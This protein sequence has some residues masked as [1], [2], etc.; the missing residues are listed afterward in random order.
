MTIAIVH[1]GGDLRRGE[2]TRWLA[3][4][5]PRALVIL[6]SEGPGVGALARDLIAH[7][8]GSRP[9]WR[10][11]RGFDT[12]TQLAV[13]FPDLLARGVDRVILVSDA[14]HLARAVPVAKV[15]A[16]RGLVIGR[17][18]CALP[19]VFSTRRRLV[20]DVLRAVA[21]RVGIRPMNTRTHR[22]RRP[23]LRA[24]ETELF[25]YTYPVEGGPNG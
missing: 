21:W 2:T 7:E 15:L 8:L 24:A 16:P 3:R 4:T 20:W 18:V 10:D 19:P 5:L 12:V 9:L 14:G 1:L 11:Y 22:E 23:M 6:S 13:L 17:G 25:P